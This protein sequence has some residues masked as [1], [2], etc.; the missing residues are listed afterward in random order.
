MSHFKIQ[1]LITALLL[2]LQGC[3]NLPVQIENPPAIDLK[4]REVNEA[5]NRHI[6]M[7]VRWGGTIIEV[8]NE[9]NATRIQILYYPLDGSGR[10]Q[11]DKPNEGRFIVESLKFLDPAVYRKDSKITVFGLLNRQTERKIGNKTLKLPVITIQTLYLWPELKYDPY[12]NTY[13]PY[14]WG[15]YYPFG[16]YRY[17]PYFYPWY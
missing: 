10:P 12:Q 7:P 3:S 14:Y 2:I 11:P 5:F 1:G 13:P 15:G 17:G 6:N 16:Y 9:E 4:Y 8:E